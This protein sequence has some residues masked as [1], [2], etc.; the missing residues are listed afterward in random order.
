MAI[1]DESSS[2]SIVSSIGTSEDVQS[3]NSVHDNPNLKITSQLLDGLNYVRWAPP[4]VPSQTSH[5]SSPSL[6]PLPTASS[7]SR[8]SRKKCDYYDLSSPPSYLPPLSVPCE[9]VIPPLVSPSVS[10]PLQVYTRRHSGRQPPT[11]DCQTSSV[12]LGLPP[13][14]D[15]P[16]SGIE[17]SP[18]ASIPVTADD[19]SLVSHTEMLNCSPPPSK[20][21]SKYAPLMYVMKVRRD[22]V[23]VIIGSGGKKIRSIIEETGVDGI[24]TQEDGVVKITSKDLTSLERCK[25][26]I[27]N[28][29]MVPNIGDVFRNCEIKRIAPFGAFVEIAPG[30][31]GLCHISELSADWVAKPEDAFKVGDRVDVKLIEINEKGQLRLSHR[32]LLPDSGASKTNPNQQTGDNTELIEKDKEQTKNRRRLSKVASPFSRV[33]ASQNSLIPQEKFTKRLVSSARDGPYINKERQ[34]KSD[35]KAVSSISGTDG[36]DLVS[37]ESKTN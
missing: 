32:A 22:K 36:S 24:E 20:K 8:P 37:E 30:C 16:L 7:N 35:N 27:A 11:P 12:V 15:S 14:I 19:D 4:S 5:T 29:T 28:L 2:S 26:I 3:F 13:A 33:N 31:E 9:S 6:S 34:N 21:L 1:G 10:R 25:T 18:T 17:P 23:N